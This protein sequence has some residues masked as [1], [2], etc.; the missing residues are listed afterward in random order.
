MRSVKHLEQRRCDVGAKERNGVGCGGEE[1][2]E[3]TGE[4]VDAETAELRRR[5]PNGMFGSR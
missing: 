5:L 2:G 1:D 3:E 4:C